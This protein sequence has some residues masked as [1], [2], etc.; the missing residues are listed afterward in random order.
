MIRSDWIATASLAELLALRAEL[1]VIGRVLGALEA[2]GMAAVLDYDFTARRAV[3]T[4][5]L[6]PLAGGDALPGGTLPPP[7]GCGAAAPAAARQRDPRP[8]GS[9]T[10]CRGDVDAMTVSPPH[11]ADASDGIEAPAA[12]PLPAAV[13]AAPSP[14]PASDPAGIEA[15]AAPGKDPAAGAAPALPQDDLAVHLARSRPG[16]SLG[17]EAALMRLHC[18]GWH[19]GEIAIDMD[20]GAHEVAA[21][22]DLLTGWDRARKAR[23]FRPQAV[24]DRL[25]AMAGVADG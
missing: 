5:A 20:R 10:R 13:G 11:P 24:R 3:L 25:D 16:W 17:D 19:S 23:R 2:A 9:V 8:P 1:T 22:I 12:A 14:L 7:G 6:P 18:L 15:P 4:C 21:R